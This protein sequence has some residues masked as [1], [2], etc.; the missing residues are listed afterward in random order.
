VHSLTPSYPLQFIKTN[1]LLLFLSLLVF[2]TLY[3]YSIQS[4]LVFGGDTMSYLQMAEQVRLGKAPLSEKWMPLYGTC[5]GLLAKIT[6]DILLSAKWVNFMFM[7]GVVFLVQF[8]THKFFPKN[9]FALIISLL[10]MLA[11]REFLFHSLNMMAELPMLFF[12]L[13][14]LF[15]L[16]HYL[17]DAIGFTYPRVALL[18]SLSVLGLFTKYNAIIVV[19]L[20]IACILFTEQ[21]RKKWKL[22]GVYIGV[23]ALFYGFWAYVK[24]GKEVV[25]TAMFKPELITDF[26]NYVHYFWIAAIDHFSAPIIASAYA[27]A[28]P[29][30]SLVLSALVTAIGL[31]LIWREYKK[32]QKIS[33]FWILP[34][35]AWLYAVGFIYI[36]STTGRFEI[37]LRQCNYPFFVLQYSMVFVFFNHNM[38]PRW[39]IVLRVLILVFIAFGI[40]KL[41]GRVKAFRTVGYGDMAGTTYTP[42]YYESVRIAMNIIEEK[43]IPTEKI[44]TDKH[45]VLGINFGFKELRKLPTST[46][47]SANRSYTLQGKEREDAWQLMVNELKQG[48]VLVYVGPDFKTQWELYSSLCVEPELDC[49]LTQDGFVVY[50]K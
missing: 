12:F 9:K 22:L 49:V 23:I 4:H 43:K 5:I 16:V 31:L 26:L 45:K 20:I 6:G 32:K 29:Y 41:S 47:W 7:L 10:L 2:G 27:K 13:W 48:G 40:L 50:G 39:G 17:S 42:T 21:K 28:S 25:V 30:A 15:L 18:A 36:A 3:W 35:F 46:Y 33:T 44:F 1:Q 8:F 14:I 38:S 11:N 24:P 37:T 19:L 34:I